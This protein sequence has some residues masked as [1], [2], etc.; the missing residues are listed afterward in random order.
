[1]VLADALLSLERLTGQALPEKPHAW[2]ITSY[3]VDIGASGAT[4]CCCRL[5]VDD[6]DHGTVL[7][8]GGFSVVKKGIWGKTVVAVKEMKQVNDRRVR[9]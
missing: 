9:P 4:C 8:D 7:G 5:I 6:V 3:D 1:M 2:T